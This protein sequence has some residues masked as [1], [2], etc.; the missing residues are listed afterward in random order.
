MEMCGVVGCAYD[1]MIESFRF[2]SHLSIDMAKYNPVSGKSAI[3]GEFVPP[4]DYYTVE[5]FKTMSTYDPATQTYYTVIMDV[6]NT[7]T[8]ILH[9]FHV[10]TTNQTQVHIPFTYKGFP[11]TTMN[12]N[13]PTRQIA[14]TFGPHL[15]LLDPKSGAIVELLQVSTC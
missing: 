13:P 4:N 7:N 14:A 9:T 8:S 3:L 15:V 6:I 5:K 12:W 11:L 1:R 2:C 10:V